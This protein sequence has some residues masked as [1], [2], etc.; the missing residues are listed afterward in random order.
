MEYNNK[1]KAFLNYRILKL[2][3]NKIEN[4]REIKICNKLLNAKHFWEVKN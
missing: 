1:Y 2:Y 4:L 3:L